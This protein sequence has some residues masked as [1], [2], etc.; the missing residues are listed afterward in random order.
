MSLRMAAGTVAIALG[1]LASTASAR[2]DHLTVGYSDWPGY[3]IWQIAI[4]KGWF[5][6][7]GIDIGFEWFDYSA[8]MD[9]FSAGKLDA[10]NVTNGDMLVMN[11]NGARTLMIIPIDYSSGNDMVIGKAGIGSLKDLKG[12]KVGVEVGLVDDLLLDYGLKASGMSEKDVE[13]VNTKTNDTPQVLASGEVAAVADWQP[14][15]GQALTAA[16]GSRPIYTSADA[17]GLIYDGLA[18]SPK[19]FSAHRDDWTKIVAIWFRAVDYAQASS[20]EAEALKIMAA[21]DNLTPDAL[22]PL[23]KGTHVLTLSEAKTVMGDRPGLDS[24][25][26]STRNAD[27][28]NVAKGLYKQAQDVK[29]TIYPSIVA[30]SKP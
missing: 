14:A 3:L 11:G 18:V 23:W 12:K 9:A 1:L 7:A 2:A 26:G 22:K 6:D 4:D 13:L 29:T 5:K 30:A 27:A 20:T 24:L 15:A 8:G 28:F 10:A 16:P 25:Y 17:P 19:S 21:R